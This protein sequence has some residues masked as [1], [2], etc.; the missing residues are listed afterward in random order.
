[1]NAQAQPGFADLI[2]KVKPAVIAVRVKIEDQERDDR[3]RHA[4]GAV[5]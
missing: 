1:M 4:D 3:Q 2:E 5:R